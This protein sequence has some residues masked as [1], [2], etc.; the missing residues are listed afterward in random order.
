M[1]FSATA[2]FVSGGVLTLL[3]TA[4][5]TKATPSQRAF[6]LMPFLF[7]AQQLSEGV[8][9]MTLPDPMA[10]DVAHS[11]IYLYLFF[12][13]IVWPVWVPLSVFLMEKDWRRRKYLGG[14][15][16]LGVVVSIYLSYCILNFFVRAEITG[17][18]IAYLLSYP[19]SVI[20]FGTV[21]YFL[22]TAVPPFLSTGKNMSWLGFILIGSFIFSRIF[23]GGFVISVWCFF[24]SILSGS[25]LLLINQMNRPLSM[26]RRNETTG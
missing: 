4:C 5:V 6:A 7:G 9:W 22:A 10:R 14:V 18:H 16:G 23:Y 17:H 26:Q 13:Q 20:P 25:I 24:A 11:M 19:N 8:L 3:G 1:C 12:A 15:L 2:S 21:F